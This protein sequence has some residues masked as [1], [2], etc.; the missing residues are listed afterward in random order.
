MAKKTK[1]SNLS[2]EERLEQAL[3]P[4]W[5]E[6]YKLP[7]NWCWV[8][9][10]AI[11]AIY[12]GNS[13]N[14]RVKEEKYTGK[15]DGLVYLA[16]KD[17]DF[18]S[19]ID[20]DTNVCIPHSDGFKVAPKYSTLL[21]I[22]G[23]SAGRKIGFIT[24]DVCFVNKL[25]AFVPHGKINPKYLYYAI[26][27]DAFKK[28]FDAKKHGL[29]GGVSVKE[30]SSIFIPFAPVEIQNKIVEL[31]E[32]VFNKLDE[33]EGKAQEVVDGF[34]TRKAAILHKAFSGEMTAKWRE[35]NGI[36]NNTWVTKSLGDVCKSIYDGDHMP[37]P[38]SESGIPFLV[39]SN[40]NTGYLSFEDTRFVPKE[41]YDNIS[42]TRKPKK[43]DVLYTLVGSYGIPVVV[44]T[45]NAFCFQRHMALLK[46]LSIDTYFL[47]YLLQ[48][49]KMYQ[50][51]SNI[52]KGVAQLTVPI[53]GLRAIEFSCP[54][55]G[56]QKEIVKLLDIL[57]KKE[58][59]AKDT[60]EAVIEQ[61]NT[62][63]KAILAR[64]FRGE[65]G[66]NNPDEESALELLKNV[67]LGDINQQ[68]PQKSS[69]KSTRI[70]NHIETALLTK[71]EKKIVSLFYITESKVVSAEE[72]MSVSSKNID[73]IDTLAKLEQRGILIRL[74]N[75]YYRIKE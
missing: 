73:I 72:I 75:S 66:T 54:S 20:Y 68:E 17:I 55:S 27:S 1:D 45:D 44:D 58:L 14:E 4:N 13:I 26:Q 10:D 6:P 31:I 52:A 74:N 51:A 11:A 12:T 48:T 33:A 53:K 62:I 65:L 25:C 35:E 3:I 63:K 24:Q 59:G 7:P 9:V 36:S 41:Y 30:V 8:R 32:S 23:G 49:Q 38:K 46:P 47:W 15:T 29:I 57:I 34:E 67:L 70:P 5:D 28:Q 21:C 61:I 42:D 37:P 56:E 22:E 71:L 39:I 64:T 18:D 50:K 40:V 60:A 19:T 16:T 2:I 43:G 69:K